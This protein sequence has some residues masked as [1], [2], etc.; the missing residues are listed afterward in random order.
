MQKI[1]KTEKSRILKEVGKLL[2]TYRLNRVI[3][4]NKKRKEKHQTQSV[5]EHVTNLMFCAHYFKELEGLNTRIDFEE[6]IKI[7]LM[8]DLGEIETGD[9]ITTRK[10]NTHILNERKGLKVVKK[11]GPSFVAKDIEKVFDNF[12][13]PE[14]LEYKF[15]KAIDKFE[16][17]LFW[18]TD[19]G[20]RMIKS[21]QDSGTIKNYFSNLEKILRD[22]DFKIILKYMQVIRDDM[23]K[24]GVL[25]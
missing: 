4:F 1:S 6:V 24:R 12:E 11:K 10:N 19:E 25:D 5:A 16:G 20:I 14:T 9:V 13:F 18:S 8:H 17:M 7:L 23:I 21:I 3:R 15:A 2:Y 22:L